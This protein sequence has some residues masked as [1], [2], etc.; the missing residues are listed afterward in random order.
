MPTHDT[1]IADESVQGRQTLNGTDDTLASLTVP[2]GELWYVDDLHVA[3][4]GSGDDSGVGVAVGV[5]DAATL[6]G[7]ESVVGRAGRGDS[8]GV[9]TTVADGATA[10]V[11]AYATGGEEVRVVEAHEGGSTGGYHYS[12]QVRKV[13]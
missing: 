3:T 4:D 2:D 9:D 7:M 6:D 8:L 13:L 5:A 12:L 1:T 10:V 11:D